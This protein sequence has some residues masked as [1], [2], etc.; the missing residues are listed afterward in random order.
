MKNGCAF[1]P[2]FHVINPYGIFAIMTT[3]RHEIVFEG[4]D[5][6]ENWKEYFFYHKPSE[7]T[8]RPRRISPYQPRID[9]QAWFLPLGSYRYD[10]WFDNFIYHLLKNSPN[11]LALLRFN[12]FTEAPPRYIRTVLYE[13][14]FSSF[15]EKK[16]QGWWWRRTR[17]GLFTQP[18]SLNYEE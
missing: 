4:S 10:T 7:I 11:V 16:E 2:P 13:Y 3:T 5:D 15:K 14:E 12:P 8:R 9:W 17:H 1:Y 18:I 6:G